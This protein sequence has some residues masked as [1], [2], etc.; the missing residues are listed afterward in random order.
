[1]SRLGVT[2]RHPDLLIPQRPAPSAVINKLTCPLFIEYPS[3]EF[4]DVLCSD[5]QGP[6][7]QIIYHTSTQIMHLNHK[8]L[9]ATDCSS[10]PTQP[11][12]GLPF[13]L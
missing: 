5:L 1:M 10:T 2:V 6:L 4:T 12:I 3:G 11:G 9:T 7:S 13:E 8:Q